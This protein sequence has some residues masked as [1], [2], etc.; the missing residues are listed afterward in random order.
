VDYVSKLT[1]LSGLIVVIV[2]V[3][4]IHFSF[5]PSKSHHCLLVYN[6]SDIDNN[7][8]RH[9]IQYQQAQQLKILSFIK[10]IASTSPPPACLCNQF[11]KNSS[12]SIHLVLSICEGNCL[13]T[14]KRLAFVFHLNEKINP[15]N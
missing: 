7:N 14:N 8:Q 15:I 3:V 1:S 12:N 4:K 13:E 9:S 11:M 5:V 2:F 10:L 6:H